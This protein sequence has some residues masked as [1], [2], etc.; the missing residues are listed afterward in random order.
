MP[1]NTRQ[2]HLIAAALLFLA[3]LPGV[4]FAG[5]PAPPAATEEG[6]P[7]SEK[8]AE[9][10]RVYV[11]NGATISWDLDNQR[12]RPPSAAQAAV[13]AREFRE[14][15]DA[16]LSDGKLPDAK[17]VVMEKLPNGYLRSRLPIQ[18]M[19]AA[20]VSVDADGELAGMCTEGPAAAAEALSVP[21]SKS[22]EVWR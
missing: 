9:A 10:D 8:A 4:V 14:W 16:K 21:A 6:E 1:S 18:T 12:F 7:A 15:M 17:D 20:M 11:I 3:F 5:D 22:E 2:I 13:L 19:N